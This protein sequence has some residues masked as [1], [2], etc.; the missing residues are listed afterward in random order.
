MKDG[1][2]E[3]R[4]FSTRD[5]AALV[6]GSAIG[7]LIVVSFAVVVVMLIARQTPST[8]SETPMLWPGVLPAKQQGGSPVYFVDATELQQEFKV[9]GA[10]ADKK[11]SEKLVEVSGVVSAVD[12][13]K[14]GKK[15]GIVVMFADDKSMVLHSVYCLMS[16][17]TEDAALLLKRG[18][19]A[20]IV[21]KYEGFSQSVLIVNCRVVR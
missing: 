12:K 20:K 10:A 8:S 2:Q 17:T 18:D 11:Y 16:P 7:V 15:E 5:K 4:Q 1:N 9:N 21:G 13:V 6:V 14:D 3:E 19:K